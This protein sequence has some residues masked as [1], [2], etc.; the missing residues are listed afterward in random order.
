M[1]NSEEADLLEWAD[2]AHRNAMALAAMFGLTPDQYSEDPL[3]LLLGF[4][5]YVKRLPF[6]EFEQSDWIALH[7]DMTS[8]LGDLL[9]LRHGA[10][11]KK[12]PDQ[13]SLV[14]YRYVVE[15][16]GLDGRTRHVEPYDVAM[17]EFE[18]PPIE[19]GRMVANAEAVLCVTPDI[20]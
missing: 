1:Q 3:V 7:A 18:N 8:Y 14:G 2:G 15:A 9:V 10:R 6:E 11:W 19:I 12:I 5:G 16:R 4:Q 13:I 20:D 17:E